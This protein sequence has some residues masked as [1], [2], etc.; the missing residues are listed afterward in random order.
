MTPNSLLPIALEAVRLAAELIRTSRPGVL[1]AKGDRDLV[2]ELD[3]TV[4][5]RLRDFLR[6]RTPS[7]GFLGEEGGAAPGEDH[8][9]T[10]TLDP[11][12][13][14]VN[15]VRGMPLTAVSLA[16]VDRSQPVLGVIDLPFLG[17]RYRATRAGGAYMNERRLQLVGARPLYEAIVAIGDFAVGARAEEKNR[18]RFEVV[19]Q[20]ATVA[21][22]VRMVGSAAI[23]MAWLA[24]GKV[25]ASITLGNDPW[26]MAAGVVIAR[27]A[28]AQVVDIDGSDYRTSS[29]ATLAATPHLI[30]KI[31]A[32]VQDAERRVHSSI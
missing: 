6:E 5:R 4:E 2:S 26:D 20:I 24:E 28:G 7:I 3:F 10:W 31:L 21:L 29:R 18:L 13:G 12:D 14:T 30:E 32:I 27:E 11:I 9:L 8:E 15:F 19:N 1:T 25:D 16:L 23:D 22:R 17:A